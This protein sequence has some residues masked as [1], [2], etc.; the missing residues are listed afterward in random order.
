MIWSDLRMKK[1]P[2]QNRE[3]QN[4]AKALAIRREKES[5][6]K[7][8]ARRGNKS[9]PNPPTTRV[10]SPVL[11]K[12]SKPGQSSPAITLIQ[13]TLNFPSKKLSGNSNL[14]ESQPTQSSL[15]ICCFLQLPPDFVSQ[16]M[17]KFQSR[18]GLRSVSR[19]TVST[20]FATPELREMI[21]SYL[22]PASVRTAGLVSR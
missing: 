20:V 2:E 18:Y 5:K 22:V 8:L 1:T 13:P 3:E 21:F 7:A 6:A 9:S 19:R 10:S 16:A 12:I 14:K 4:K 17:A 15:L 11:S